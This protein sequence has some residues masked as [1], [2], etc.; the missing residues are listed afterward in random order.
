MLRNTFLHIEGFGSLKELSLWKS[1]ITTWDEFINVNNAQLSLFEEYP[2]SS[3]LEKSIKAF[4][5]GDADFFAKKLPST[6]FYRIALTY[7]ENV[8]FLDIETTGLSRYYDHITLIGWSFLNEYNVYYLGLNKKKII[9]AFKKAKCIVTYNGSLFDIPFI[10]KEFPDLNIPTCQ[11]DLRFFSKRFG[12]SGGL[13]KI[14]AEI[15]FSRPS[16]V[17]EVSGE[18][19]PILWYKYMEGDEDSLKNLI[20]YN[21]FDIDG[22]KFLLDVCVKKHIENLHPINKCIN[23]FPFS[24]YLSDLSFS[25]KDKDNSI[26]LKKYEGNIG[27]VL[28]FKDL[29]K[30]KKLSVVGIDLTGSEEKA[31]G[32]CHLSYD[33]AITK[34]INSN[35]D[36]I[37]E[38]LKCKPDLVS[39]DSPLSLPIGRKTVF[40][41]DEGRDEF[42][43]MRICERILKKRG[44]SVYPSLIP[45]MQKLTQRGILLANEFR[46]IGVPVIESYPGA[47]QDILGIPRKGTSLEYLVK[48]LKAF[49]IKGKYEDV[50][51]DELDAITSA[52]LG[53]FFWCGKFEAL[54]NEQENYLIIPDVEK[55]YPDWENKFVVGFSG[56][57]SAGKT[58]AGEYLKSNGYTYGRFSMVIKDLVEKGGK[59]PIR[60]NLQEM[61]EYVNREKGQRWLC[62]ELIERFFRNEG[63][64]VID[65]LRFPDDHAYLKEKYGRHFIHIHITCD[66]HIR[67]ERYEACG[68]VNDT[69]F[70]YAINHNVEKDVAKLSKLADVII[71]NNQNIDYLYT[72]LNR[73][74]NYKN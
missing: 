12:Y 7:P 51:H 65:G 9:S 28:T 31:T 22:M 35:A 52:M 61:G 46:K 13:K 58:T 73:Y 10:R 72:Q 54:G 47:A 15:G 6:E 70:Y 56:G 5:D 71:T 41:D 53:Y 55:S 36:L 59:K 1:G 20:N 63:K 68:G 32:W 17:N 44:V 4:E 74:I 57:L 24:N 64:I 16:D 62:Q 19:A 49:G 21:R 43:I 69:P 14:E 2:S 66:E 26:F 60:S 45:S 3:I 48:G 30:Y 50:S 23:L 29:P 33:K 18:L 34:R 25:Y 11:I 38:T 42:G 40:D 39:I 27:P 67:K 8:M 37:K